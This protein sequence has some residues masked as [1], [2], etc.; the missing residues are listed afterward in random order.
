M[1][2]PGKSSGSSGSRIRAGI[3]AALALIGSASGAQAHCPTFSGGIGI[4]G[5]VTTF[6]A[7]TLPEGKFALGLRA[8]LTGFDPLPAAELDRAVMEGGTA[9]SLKQQQV[10][11]L[12]G[13][14]GVGDDLTLGVSLPYVVRGGIKAVHFDND[15]QMSMLHDIGESDG[16]GDLTLFGQYRLV[17]KLYEGIEFSLL[18]GLKTPTGVTDNRSNGARI[19]TEHQPGSGSWDPMAGAAFSKRFQRLSLHATGLYSLATRGAQATNLGDRA[20]LTVAAAYRFGGKENYGDCDEIYEYFYPESRER[21]LSDLVLEVNGNW[22]DKER[23]AGVRDDSSGGTV[24]YLSPGA[25]VTYDSRYSGSV[26]VGVPIYQQWN[27]SQ[28]K[29]DYRVIAAL[30]VAF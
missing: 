21:W 24:L 4:A 18:A 12:G 28:S 22:Q 17:R 29:V 8:D 3:V 16:V 26:S 13:A 1:F 10:Y 23:V 25:R 2:T 30:S 27:G 7:S 20:Q 15:M 19:E 9:H 5:P 14:Y 11:S 6:S